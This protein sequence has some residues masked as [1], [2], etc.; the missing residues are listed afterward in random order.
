MVYSKN[1]KRTSQSTHR[2]DIFN[3]KGKNEWRGK[4]YFCN[5]ARHFTHLKWT[6]QTFN[7]ILTKHRKRVLNRTR[8]RLNEIEP[9][10]EKLEE[11]KKRLKKELT[12]F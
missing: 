4:I 1:Y 7:D 5:V 9:E 12:Y 8:K 6:A 10:F 3:C 11:E 2:T